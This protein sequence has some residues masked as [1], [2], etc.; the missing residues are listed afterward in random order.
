M[1]LKLSKGLNPEEKILENISILETT[2]E[3][4]NQ[5]LK[6]L[7]KNSGQE[8]NEELASKVDTLLESQIKISQSMEVLLR[9]VT[10]RFE[11]TQDELDYLHAQQDKQSKVLGSFFEK[12]SEVVNL[13]KLTVGILEETVD[14]MKDS[15]K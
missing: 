13:L 12:E 10:K 3:A 1:S 2:V 14:V 7:S 15:S 4:L 5:H 8:F 11:G 9:E 6:I